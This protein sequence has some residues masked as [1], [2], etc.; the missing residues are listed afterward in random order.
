MAAEPRRVLSRVLACTSAM[1]VL[2]LLAGC[3]LKP[4][5]LAATSANA[6][7][8]QVITVTIHARDAKSIRARQLY[9]WLVVVNC[10]GGQGRYP[11]EPSISGQPVSNFRFP[12]T[13]NRVD[14]V[15]RVPATIYARYPQ[16]CALLEGGGYFTGKIKSSIIPIRKVQGAGP[17]SSSKPTPLR[18]AA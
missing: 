13:G 5:I 6:G 12:V 11:S 16:P 7:D 2:F 10:A 4:R 3:Q 9:T 8:E 1:C 14:L 15:A 18:G 17:N